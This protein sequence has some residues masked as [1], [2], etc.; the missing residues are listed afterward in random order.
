MRKNVLNVES[1]M[2]G[3]SRYILKSEINVKCTP[4]TYLNEDIE[5][6][7]LNMTTWKV[8]VSTETIWKNNS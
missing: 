8:K 5:I 3:L 4:A 6:P 1:E 2:Q 7:A